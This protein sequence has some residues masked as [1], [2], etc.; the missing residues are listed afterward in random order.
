MN[1][2]PRITKV[3]TVEIEPSGRVII[4]GDFEFEQASCREA[5]QLAI[6][7]AVEKLGAALVED[8]T[9][10]SPNLSARE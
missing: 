2:W 8:M 1:G 6:A 4:R 3:G 9:A 5:C 10:D 7:W